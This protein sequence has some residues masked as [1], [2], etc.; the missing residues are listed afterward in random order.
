MRIRIDAGYPEYSHENNYTPNLTGRENSQAIS[1][2]LIFFM[3][4]RKKTKK[5]DCW[6]FLGHWSKVE[7]WLLIWCYSHFVVLDLDCFVVIFL[8]RSKIQKCIEF[9][10]NWINILMMIN[11]RNQLNCK[12]NHNQWLQYVAHFTIFIEFRSDRTFRTH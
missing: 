9:L 6:W 10:T 1:D 2:W 7:L 5:L 11:H 4:A 3:M 8:F 12:Y